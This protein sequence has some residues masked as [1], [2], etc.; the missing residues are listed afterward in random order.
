MKIEDSPDTF[1][2][3]FKPFVGNKGKG[4]TFK[5]LRNNVEKNHNEGS[6]RNAGQLPLTEPDVELF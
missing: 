4:S 5:K 3:T 1:Y 2:D 6:G